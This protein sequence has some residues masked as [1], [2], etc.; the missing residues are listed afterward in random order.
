MSGPRQSWTVPTDLKE[1]RLDQFARRCLPHLSRRTLERAIGDKLFRVNGKIAK[2]GTKL[3]AGAVLSFTG[4]DLWL[5]AEPAAVGFRVPILYEDSSLLIV[6]KPAGMATHGF[7]GRETTTL[8]NFLAAVRPEVRGVGKSR[9][10]PGLVH[11]IDRETSGLVLVAKTQAVF[12]HLRN[13]FRR[14]QIEKR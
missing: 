2:K 11:R 14:H 6:D 7:S 1:I 9:W 12:E 3:S 13:Q 10:E 5:A 8:T 4:P